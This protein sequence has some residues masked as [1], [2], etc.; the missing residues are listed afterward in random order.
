MNKPVFDALLTHASPPPLPPTTSTRPSSSTTPPERSQIDYEKEGTP[1]RSFP[2]Q[3]AP[4]SED[5]APRLLSQQGHRE[6][7]V[8]SNHFGPSSSAPEKSSSSSSSSPS[9]SNPPRVF[10]ATA[11]RP[12]LIFVASRRQTRRTA[13]E[14]IALLHTQGDVED[15]TLFLDVREEEQEAFMKTLRSVQV[16]TTRTLLI[17]GGNLSTPESVDLHTDTRNTGIV[18]F[19]L[20]CLPLYVLQ[21]FPSCVSPT[22]QRGTGCRLFLWGWGFMPETASLSS[23]RRIFF[24]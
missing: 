6:E 21:S 9:S 24:V 16:N 23:P 15:H 22:Q 14:L 8:Y 13:N 3:S 17:E 10:S 1:R 2:E 5:S 19:F 11:L 7:G 18:S 20:L 12:S 4:A